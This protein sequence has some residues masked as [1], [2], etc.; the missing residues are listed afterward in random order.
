MSI[1]VFLF[2]LVIWGIIF[3]LFWWLLGK[4]ALPEPSAKVAT[5]IL[6][7]AAIYV[8]IGLLTG[9]IAPFYFSGGGLRLR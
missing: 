5:V 7:V 1:V 3:W 4:I 8:I 6:A 9:S 2:S